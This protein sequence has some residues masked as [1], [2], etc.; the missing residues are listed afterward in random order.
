MAVV[1]YYGEEYHYDD[2]GVDRVDLN[3]KTG[4]HI[5]ITVP[6]PILL[7]PVSDLQSL[8][9][10]RKSRLSHHLYKLSDQIDAN[11]RK[12]RQDIPT[13]T[14]TDR[15]KHSNLSATKISQ[16]QPPTVHLYIST[17]LKLQYEAN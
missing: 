4:N 8:L 10:D 15:T 12:V 6:Y 11:L 14:D 2:W 17:L 16:L 1:E 3:F 9:S 13:N 5:Y 7:F